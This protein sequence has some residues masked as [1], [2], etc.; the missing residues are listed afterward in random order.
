MFLGFPG[1][2]RGASEMTKLNSFRRYRVCRH[3]VGAN[4]V[5]EARQTSRVEIQ[6]ADRFLLR[7][8]NPGQRKTSAP[9]ANAQPV[10][11]FGRGWIFVH[12]RS[13]TKQRRDE[14][15]LQQASTTCKHRWTDK[16]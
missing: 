13:I 12:G 7:H 9:C 4:P 15:T 5:G 16:K 10:N 3:A 11:G 6:S 1:I 2:A 8:P 14:R